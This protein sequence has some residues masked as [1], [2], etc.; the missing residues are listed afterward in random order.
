[1]TNTTRF[2]AAAILCF[3]SAAVAQPLPPPDKHMPEKAEMQRHMIEMCQ[4]RKAHT[5]GELTYLE[6]KLAL[7]DKQKPLFERWKKVKLAEANAIDCALPPE[8]EPS[9]VDQLKHEEKFLHARLDSLKAELPTLEA[10]Y[11]TLSDDQKKVFRPAPPPGAKHGGPMMGHGPDGHG[12]P[13]HQ[14]PNDMPAP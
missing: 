4:D 11:A 8:G 3:S 10:F 9:L 12:D 13:G 1:M 2:F 7:N 6:T 14:P 5:A